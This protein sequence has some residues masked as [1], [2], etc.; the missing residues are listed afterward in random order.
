MLIVRMR[1][2]FR[3]QLKNWGRW[4]LLLAASIFVSQ[5]HAAESPD[6]AFYDG[7]LP[8]AGTRSLFDQL[9]MQNGG[10]AYP[11]ES[12]LDQ[13][14]K[15]S[16]TKGEKSLV[17][18]LI[19]DGRSLVRGKTDNH[20]PRVMVAVSSESG[21]NSSMPVM[22]N[23][24]FISLV[25][26]A[27]QLEV[28]SYNEAAG[29]FEF[30]V[31]EDYRDNATPRIF[32]AS[33]SLCMTCHQNAATIFS[34]RPWQETN[35]NPEVAQAIAEARSS[36][37]EKN[38]Q[39]GGFRQPLSEAENYDAL[40]DNANRLLTSQRIWME[41]CGSSSQ[42]LECRRL[43]LKLALQFAWAP[44]LYTDKS[45]DYRRL[46]ELQSALWPEYG[47]DLHTA[48]L[49]NRNPYETNT[50]PLESILD[51]FRGLLSESAEEL[52]SVVS[53][54]DEINPMSFRPIQKTLSSDSPSGIFGIAQFFT[55]SDL[56][57]LKGA[58][59]GSFEVVAELIDEGALDV[60]INFGPMRRI[61]VLDKLRE[62]LKMPVQEEMCC[63]ENNTM[64]EPEL[65]QDTSLELANDSPLIPFQKYCFACHRG[66]PTPHLDFMKG[67]D[68][69]TVWANIL[70]LRDKISRSLEW[71][72]SGEPVKGMMPPAGSAQWR[73]MQM[74]FSSGDNFL[75]ALKTGLEQGS[76]KYQYDS[77]TSGP[78]LNIILA[79]LSVLLLGYLSLA[80]LQIRQRM[81][82]Q[83]VVQNKL[84]ALWDVRLSEAFKQ[85]EQMQDEGIAWSGY[86]K[87]EIEKRVDE[88]EGICSLY[89]RPHDR[90]PLPQF[91]PGQYLTL[92]L[93]I[94]EQERPVIRCYSLSDA[95][96]ESHYRIT[97][98]YHP[99]AQG[100]SKGLASSFIHQY[101]R[102][103]DI[104]DIRAPMGS[105]TLTPDTERVVFIAGGIG[106]TPILSMLK[107]LSETGIDREIWLF[108][109]VHDGRFHIEKAFLEKIAI[110]NPRFHLQ[111]CYSHPTEMDAELQSFTHETRINL[112]LL[113]KSLKD[114][115][116]DFFMCGPP[117]MIK[118]LYEELLQWGATADHIHVETFEAIQLAEESSKL[119][120]K[121][122]FSVSFARSG[123]T[124]KWKH[125]CRSLLEFAEQ[126]DIIL[127]SGCRA[128]NCGT[129]CVAIRSGTVEYT[130]DHDMQPEQG[131][132]L[133]CV[134]VPASDLVLD[135]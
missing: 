51:W 35:A 30:Q 65:L 64:P 21:D 88:A 29:R 128:G 52:D 77:H 1:A 81:L 124:V 68:E 10:L 41:G 72:Y 12:L 109:G 131:S 114:P 129:C 15:Y 99:E 22:R 39:G 59:N 107:S 54:P 16:G 13:I 44:G 98:K 104:V 108:Y 31:V 97:V 70:P 58:A 117:V 19:P 49:P 112:N 2:C 18:L 3:K 47:I 71:D 115:A 48:N 27:S 73:N 50:N 82:H 94:P 95:P 4:T 42:S 133:A 123:K 132:C 100:K 26:E 17:H 6:L 61:A 56:Q 87:F 67:I 14:R 36:S 55:V 86:R 69:K 34:V 43:M 110:N 25:E 40:T 28:I 118:G 125:D 96:E 105:F 60:V 78:L 79:A 75:D 83:A 20:Q 11:F 113:Q 85:Y 122:D 127:D 8:P 38:Y 102:E 66:N 45:P 74:A 80:L 120:V 116:G 32:Y 91:Q 9:V 119:F 33:R 121:N 57:A 134:C 7:D 46:M 89:L 63:I 24:L 62:L 90:T 93:L 130:G 103:D 126:H 53:M 106:I 111:V 23:R 37:A 5:L 92:R 84:G 101:L 135:A 76:K